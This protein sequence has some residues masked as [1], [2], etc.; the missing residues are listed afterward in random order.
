MKLDKVVFELIGGGFDPG[1]MLRRDPGRWSAM[2]TE[3]GIVAGKTFEC[4]QPDPE[5][6]ELLRLDEPKVLRLGVTLEAE[7]TDPHTEEFPLD[8]GFV[9]Q[10]LELVG[11]AN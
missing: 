4:Y 7:G 3:T 11:L 6:S 2:T 1:Y 10:L 5:A 8:A 9:Q